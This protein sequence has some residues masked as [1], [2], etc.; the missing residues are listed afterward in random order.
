MGLVSSVNRTLVLRVFAVSSVCVQRGGVSS[1]RMQRLR[2]HLH[3]LK[4][5]IFGAGERGK[6]AMTGII[7]ELG[8]LA[9]QTVP[10]ENSHILG[11]VAQS[12]GHRHEHDE[13]ARDCKNTP[14]RQ[15]S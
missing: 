5:P 3:M 15:P 14:R 2:W 6:K 9:R 12:D 7:C 13:Q 1:R 8:R 11:T 10:C 4:E